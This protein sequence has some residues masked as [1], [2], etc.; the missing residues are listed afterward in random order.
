VPDHRWFAGEPPDEAL[1]V[2]GDV[3]DR[4]AGEH[5][6]VDPGVGD[7]RRV[8]R[9]ARGHRRVAGIL[10]VVDPAVP[11]AAEQ[12]QAVDENDRRA[13][14]RVRPLQ[15]LLVAA[16]RHLGVVGHRQVPPGTARICPG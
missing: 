15:L 5:G 6:R 1:Q 4:L 10:D 7:R 12:P 8:V 11:A 3:A 2:T 16:C 9:P 13:A 14:G